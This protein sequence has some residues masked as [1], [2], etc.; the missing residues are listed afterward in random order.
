METKKR[1]RLDTASKHQFVA[2]MNEAREAHKVTNPNQPFNKASFLRDF[3][4]RHNTNI[5]DSTARDLITAFDDP[6][7]DRT[8]E[9]SHQKSS[10]KT[11]NL[12][13]LVFAY[14]QESATLQG[15]ED[16]YFSDEEFVRTARVI[17][18]HLTIVDPARIPGYRGP[19]EPIGTKW[20]ENFK[21]RRTESNIFSTEWKPSHERAAALTA[22]LLAQQAQKPEL[23]QH[24]A[25]YYDEELL[26]YGLKCTADLQSNQIIDIY[27]GNTVKPP[28]DRDILRDT[29]Y[30]YSDEILHDIWRDGLHKPWSL[31]RF[32][33]EATPDPRLTPPS[34]DGPDNLTFETS[35]DRQHVLVK[36]LRA[37][38][39]GTILTI[40][41]G[42]DYW[43]PLLLARVLPL[44]L[45]A[46]LRAFHTMEAEKKGILHTIPLTSD[47]W[48][49]PKTKPLPPAPSFEGLVHA[50]KGPPCPEPSSEEDNSNDSNYTESNCT[51][52]T[53]SE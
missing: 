17:H 2:E 30:V 4:Q 42:I 5:K 43:L 11:P 18:H 27:G 8:I 35:D 16:F 50:V 13:S 20:L 6:Q 22:T 45:H 15:G 10:R 41:Y 9:Y 26:C 1:S 52:S 32:A 21:A 31:S 24:L 53:Y 51:D 36:T 47:P 39:A 44:Q 14:F 46:R 38:P 40:D 34:I 37:I 49:P 48:V 19:K 3:N 7:I 28:G 12:T 25:V 29:S 33:N 23:C